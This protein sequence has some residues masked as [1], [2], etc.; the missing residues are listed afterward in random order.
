MKWIRWIAIPVAILAGLLLVSAAVIGFAVLIAYDNLPPIDAL[1]EYRPK[2]PLKI[3]TADG[4]LIGE[5]GEERRAVVRIGEVPARPS[6]CARWAT[7]KGT[8]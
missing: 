8:R 6:Y 7:T 2:I 5:F 4:A 3:F 1:T